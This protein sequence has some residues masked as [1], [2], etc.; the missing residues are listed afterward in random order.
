M[1]AVGMRIHVTY[2]RNMQYV[3]FIEASIAW[4]KCCICYTLFLLDHIL[5]KGERGFSLYSKWTVLANPLSSCRN[6]RQK[7]RQGVVY[8][9]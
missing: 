7:F 2:L 3:E 8:L 4:R 1:T 5:A 6:H 9:V